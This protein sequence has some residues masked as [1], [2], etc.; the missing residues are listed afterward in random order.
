VNKLTKKFLNSFRAGESGF[1]LI[2]LL[3]VIAI[4]GILAAVII[5]NVSKFIGTSHVSAANSELAQVGTA[6]QAAAA[7]QTGGVF[8]GSGTYTGF[9]LNNYSLNGLTQTGD[10]APDPNAATLKQYITGKLA[11]AYWITP[12]G[13]VQMVTGSAAPVKNGAS[14]TAGDPCYLTLY[15]DETTAQFV[16]SPAGQGSTASGDTCTVQCTSLP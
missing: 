3:I 11:G 8:T 13:T 14:V 2:E 15:W 16:G 4:L 10:A 5:P 6:A 12:T 1:T 7:A 9:L